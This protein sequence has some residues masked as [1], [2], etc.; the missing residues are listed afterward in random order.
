[1]G[2]PLLESSC[3]SLQQYIV[4]SSRLLHYHTITIQCTALVTSLVHCCGHGILCCMASHLLQPIYSISY[5]RT[6]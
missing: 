5:S 4:H 6:L 2:N 3:C 1:M